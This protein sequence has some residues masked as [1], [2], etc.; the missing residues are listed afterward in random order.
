MR[1]FVILALFFLNTACAT[2]PKSH[3]ALNGI[4]TFGSKRISASNILEQYGSQID[5]WV[6]ASKNQRPEYFDL[7][8][9]IEDSIKNQF[10]FAFVNLSLITYFNPNPGDYLTVDIVEPQDAAK[11][12]A[13]L[14]EPKGH[15]EDPEGLIALWEE[16]LQLAFELQRAGQFDYPSV[17]KQAL[18][19]K[20]CHS[21]GL[22][23]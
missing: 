8:K 16:Y 19:I 1:A 13:F 10:G 20:G 15:F 2:A 21:L 7:K 3:A 18:K 14:P 23:S 6:E 12:M 4:D 11:R 5:K 9:G 22:P 17:R